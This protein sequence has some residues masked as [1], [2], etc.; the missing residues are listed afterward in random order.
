MLDLPQ[1]TATGLSENS[2]SAVVGD[3]AGLTVLGT[4]VVPGFEPQPFAALRRS[5]R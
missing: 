4:S 5:G 1:P 3:G 2:A